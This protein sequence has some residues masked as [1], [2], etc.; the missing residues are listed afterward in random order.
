VT[1]VQYAFPAIFTAEEVGE[2]GQVYTVEFPDILGCITEGESI[3]QA[4]EMAREALAV[5]INAMQERREAI[6][7]PTPVEAVSHES[8]FVSIVDLGM[9]EYKQ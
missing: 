3:P 5:C 7:H 6:P 8:G 1:I 9:L 2:R 4:I